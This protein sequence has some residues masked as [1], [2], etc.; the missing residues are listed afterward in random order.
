MAKTEQVSSADTL[1]VRV[2]S[3][4]YFFF[5]AEDG[6]RDYKVTGVQTCALP[7][8]LHLPAGG[9]LLGAIGGAAALLAA[10]LVLSA[11]RWW[12]VL[13]PGVAPWAV[14][15]RLYFVGQ[16]FSLFL[17]T[18]V[19]GDAVRVLALSRATQETGRALSS[20]LI[21]R[22]LGVGALVAYLVAG[23]SLTPS[24]LLTPLHRLTWRVGWQAGVGVLGAVSGGGGLVRRYWQRWPRLVGLARAWG[25]AS[26]RLRGSPRLSGAAALAAL[27]IQAT[28][29]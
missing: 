11:L 21:E 2:M 5:Q 19:G 1:M 12:L 14:L 27:A 7:I 10:A 23:A 9:A 8:Y 17:P 4:S 22:L 13:G 15:V 25:E 18:S 6:I 24:L 28:Y 29:I 16:F 26:S 20:V 3:R